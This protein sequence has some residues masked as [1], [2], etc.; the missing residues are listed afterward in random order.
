MYTYYMIAAMGPKYQKYLWWKKY[1][2]TI[3]LVSGKTG[4]DLSEK[5][6]VDFLSMSR[7]DIESLGF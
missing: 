5:L 1:I 6:H 3:Q 2:T 7:I 4:N